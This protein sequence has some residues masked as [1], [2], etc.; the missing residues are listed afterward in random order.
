MRVD[1]HWENQFWPDLDDPEYVPAETARIYWTVKNIHGTREKPNRLAVLKSPPRFIGGFYWRLKLYPRGDQTSSLSVYL[2]CSTKSYNDDDIE[3]KSNTAEDTENTEASKDLADD[4]AGAAVDAAGSSLNPEVRD[5]DSSMQ[6]S[7]SSPNAEDEVPWEVAAQFGV[8]L[9][10]PAEPRVQY[11]FNDEHQFWNGNDDFGRKYFHGPWTEIHVRQRGQRQPLLR[12]DTLA[13]TAY[14]RIVKDPTGS[15]WWRQRDDGPSWNNLAKSGLA[16]L[17]TRMEGEGFFTAGMAAWLHL[18]SFQDLVYGFHAPIQDEEPFARPKPL[19][20]A[21][22]HVL[23]HMLHEVPPNNTVELTP[24]VQ[25]LKWYGVDFRAKIDTLEAWEIIR[26][27]MEQEAEGTA[28]KGK[29]AEL[30][31]PVTSPS[32]DMPD[33]A[34][35]FETSNPDYP[36]IRLPAR[37][38]GSIQESLTKALEGGNKF[39]REV[40]QSAPKLLQV[41]LE[42]QVFDGTTRKWRKVNNRV[43]LDEKLELPQQTIEC[44][45]KL[46]YSL[47]GMIVHRGALQSGLYYLVIRPGGPGTKWFRFYGEREGYQVQCITRKKAIREHE[48]F[49]EGECDEET[50]AVAY[51]V[52]YIRD[53][54]FNDN[55]NQRSGVVSRWLSKSFIS[56]AFRSACS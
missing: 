11:S 7:A 8:V 21:L 6:D 35:S 47:Y 30:F 22:Q 25:A 41:E 55:A 4:K 10:N 34:S 27:K 24:I 12:N 49:Q 16:G 37:C 9:Y 33:G 45:S 53:D 13:L 1:K 46:T 23:H 32:R 20:T 31:G 54:V 15:L 19:F 5:P 14:I 39:A 48:G 56:I 43:V 38:G 26:W 17:Y 42:R 36:C 50:A 18:P 40:I 3:Q 44:G 52:M 29:L 51:L 2:E 28:T